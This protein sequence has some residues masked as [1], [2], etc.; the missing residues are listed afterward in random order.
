M[1]ENQVFGQT[2]GDS[3]LLYHSVSLSLKSRETNSGISLSERLGDTSSTIFTVVYL[4][5]H[6]PPLSGPF[7]SMIP[8][9]FNSDI[10]HLYHMIIHELQHSYHQSYT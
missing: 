7:R 9:F 3:I 5:F 10:Y 2:G 6:S 1:P 4:I 8:L